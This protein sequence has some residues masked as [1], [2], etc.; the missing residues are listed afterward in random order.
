M[1]QFRFCLYIFIPCFPLVNNQPQLSLV[2]HSR[3]VFRLKLVQILYSEEFRRV[4]NNKYVVNTRMEQ[5]RRV[6]GELMTYLQHSPN[7]SPLIKQH[8]SHILNREIE[9]QLS[10]LFRSAQ[11]PLPPATNMEQVVNSL[12]ANSTSLPDLYETADSL[13]VQ[14]AASPHFASACTIVAQLWSGGGF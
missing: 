3:R 11:F 4:R 8:T 12:T 10:S 13:L 9:E 2:L 7:A 6:F 5:L 1:F 14:G